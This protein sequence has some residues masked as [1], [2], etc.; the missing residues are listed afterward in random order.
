MSEIMQNLQMR[1]KS[2]S[3]GL[4]VF[5][6]KLLSAW[7]LGYTMALIAQEI[8]GTGTVW[9]TFVV[10]AYMVAFL[11]VSRNWSGFSVLVFDLICVLVGLLLRMYIMVAPGA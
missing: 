7:V 5:I 1:L 6:F 11:M 4:M 3:T 2:T 8:F 9:F 10:V